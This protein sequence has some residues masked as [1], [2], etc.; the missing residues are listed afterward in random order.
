MMGTLLH[1]SNDNDRTYLVETGRSI[2]RRNS[3]ELIPVE[4]AVLITRYGREV[5]Q[6]N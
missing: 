6:T 1:E 2:V 5:R 4:K 3:S